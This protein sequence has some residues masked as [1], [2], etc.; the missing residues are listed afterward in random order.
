MANL[1]EK[2][3][4]DANGGRGLVQQ[5]LAGL[6]VLPTGLK[7]RL[8]SGVRAVWPGANRES[9]ALA[10]FKGRVRLR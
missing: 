2:P 4:L 8:R 6:R 5:L 9:S 1:L 10:C 3:Y 7:I